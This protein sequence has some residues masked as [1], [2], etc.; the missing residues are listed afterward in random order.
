[1]RENDF[2][3]TFTARTFVM[4]KP[5]LAVW[6]EMSVVSNIP[7]PARRTNDA[8]ICVIA[9]ARSLR[10][11]PDVI[12]TLP[13]DSPRPLDA[14]GDGRRGTNASTTAAAI[15]SATPTHRS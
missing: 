14:S 12:R 13:L 3:G 11:V 15:A 7:A 1:M 9:N 10:F 8:A 2:G 5:V 6:R 4:L